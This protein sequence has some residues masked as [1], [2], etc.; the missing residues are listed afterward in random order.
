VLEVD[1]ARTASTARDFLLY[2]YYGGMV[3]AGARRPGAR[4]AA[5]PR[6]A[7]HATRRR[8]CRLLSARRTPRDALGALPRGVAAAAHRHC[9]TSAPAR[10]FQSGL[11]M[12]SCEP[13]ALGAA[14]WAALPVGS[15]GRCDQRAW[16]PER[17]ATGG[18]P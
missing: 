13:A 2:C 6:L 16:G 5:P 10:R 1:P 18:L 7:A 8:S 11:A 15:P 17:A 9:L 4:R 14:R 12:A 3:H